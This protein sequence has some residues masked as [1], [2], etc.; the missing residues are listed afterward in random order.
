MD[1][2]LGVHFSIAFVREHAFGVVAGLHLPAGKEPVP[3]TILARLHPEEA[4]FARSLHGYRQVEWAGGRLAWAAAAARFGAR[5]APLLSGAEREPLPPPGLSVSITH[6]RDL[7]IALVGDVARGTLGIDLENEAAPSDGVAER[8]LRPEELLAV[9]ALPE[10]ARAAA[11]LLRFSVKE[12]T[13]KAIYPLLR[14]YVGYSEASVDVAATGEIS[15]TMLLKDGAE[16]PGLEATC[17]RLPGR[18]L[19]AVRCVGG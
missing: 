2:E 3:E 4:A 17:E 10:S 8:I 19:S 11:I 16:P 9:A 7:A 13:Y 6:K 12:A 18:I 14:R 15:V 5:P 1:S